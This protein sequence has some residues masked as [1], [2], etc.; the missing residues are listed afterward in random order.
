MEKCQKYPHHQIQKILRMSFDSLD[1]DTVKNTFLDI[2]CFFVGMDKDYT[3]KIFGG[4]GIFPEIG[5]NILIQRSLVTINGKNGLRMHDLIRDMG[6]EIVRER[7]SNDLGK[8]SRLLFH[9]DVLYLYVFN[10]QMVRSI[11]NHIY[12]YKHLNIHEH[13]IYLLYRYSWVLSCFFY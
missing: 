5:I 7:S 12:I 13:I 11:N 2:V 8:S 3:I 9:D 10:K 1:D 4:C 6:R